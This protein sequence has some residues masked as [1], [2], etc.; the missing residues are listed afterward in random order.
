M[1]KNDLKTGMVV[2]LR[3][4]KN[5]VLLYRQSRDVCSFTIYNSNNDEFI[6]LSSIGN[7]SDD[8]THNYNTD[9][10]IM[11]IYCVFGIGINLREVIWER[12]EAK[13]MTLEQI[14]KALGYKVKVVE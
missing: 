5:C 3:G 2:D 10:D 7:Y 6:G 11:R 13:E 8:L 9:Y 14:N 1:T 4:E 12:D